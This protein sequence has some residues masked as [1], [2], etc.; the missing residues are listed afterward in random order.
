MQVSESQFIEVDVGLRKYGLATMLMGLVEAGFK[1]CLK[2]KLADLDVVLRETA[3]E[4]A[5]ERR[6]RTVRCA[7]RKVMYSFYVKREFTIRRKMYR[8]SGFMESEAGLSAL[9][10]SEISC[11]P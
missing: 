10:V 8:R 3:D 7:F 9:T 5:N 6:L 4:G 1:G 11:S 2:R